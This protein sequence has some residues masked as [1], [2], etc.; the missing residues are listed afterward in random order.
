MY[1]PPTEPSRQEEFEHIVM[2]FI[3]DQEERIRQLE[4][5]MQDITDEFMEFSSEVTLRLKEMIKENESKPQKI[6][7]ITKYPDTKVLE[8]STK[9]YF[10][11]NLEKKTF[12]TLASHLCVRYIWLIPSY[13]PLYKWSKA[14]LVTGGMEREM[15]LLEFGW[16]VGLYS[17]RES[18]EVATLSGLRNAVTVNAAHFTH[19][20]WPTIGDGGYNVRNTKAKSIRNPRIM[21]A[22]CCLTRR[23]ETTHRMRV[24]MELHEGKCC[25][26]ATREVTGEGGGDDEEGDGEGRNKGIGG[27]ADNYRNMSQGEWQVHQAQWMGQQDERWGRLDTWMGNK[28]KEPVGCMITPSASFNTCRPATTLSHTS[29]LIRF[30]GSKP[31]TLLMAIRDTCLPATHTAPTL[32]RMAPLDHS[33]F[34]LVLLSSLVIRTIMV[35]FDEKKLGSSYE[36]SLDN[37]WMTI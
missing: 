36:V 21:L 30:L 28:T 19:L 26:P 33:C 37:S 22:Y 16:I 17:E 6:K 4:N 29:R 20:F 18:Q 2:N 24:I 23:K 34:I 7:K 10:F 9:H 1:R 25:W 32:L 15:H 13:E 35:I 11:E 27:S 12:P 31:T 5:Y 8:N 14:L 3:Y